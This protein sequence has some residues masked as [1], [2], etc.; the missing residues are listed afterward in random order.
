MFQ[1]TPGGKNLS[2]KFKDAAGSGNS[3]GAFSA[4]QGLNLHDALVSCLE[5]A[6]ANGSAF[7]AL[8][9]AAT[10]K[11]RPQFSVR[12]VKDGAVPSEPFKG[13]GADND[14]HVARVFILQARAQQKKVVG[15]L[16]SS[17]ESI[18][19]SRLFYH[20]HVRAVG[21]RRDRICAVA[22][23]DVGRGPGTEEQAALFSLGGLYNYDVAKG[24]TRPSGTT[25]ILVARSVLYAAG[26]N[27]IS[28]KTSRG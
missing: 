1:V 20:D 15:C 5:L 9:A 23:A 28:A 24:G 25:C 7:D 10:M 16:W 22:R 3:S 21:D 12:L 27:M 2:E 19:S 26:C 13:I 8:A 18:A 4:L 17:A 6:E 11:E 14:Y